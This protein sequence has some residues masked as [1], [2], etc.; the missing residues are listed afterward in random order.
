LRGLIG[1]GTCKRREGAFDVVYEHADEQSIVG[2]LNY[3]LEMTGIGVCG[4]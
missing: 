1:E 4:G 3:A 2:D